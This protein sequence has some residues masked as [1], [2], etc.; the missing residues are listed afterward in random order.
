MATKNKGGMTTAPLF[1]ATLVLGPGWAVVAALVGGMAYRIALRLCFP[2]MRMSWYQL[3]F[4]VA[5][6][7]WPKAS[8]CHADT[9]LS[10]NTMRDNGL[11][12][13]EE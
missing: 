8:I 10:E 11:K 7:S 2:K 1:V 9:L 13:A 5:E 12:T 3:V 6:T 4:N